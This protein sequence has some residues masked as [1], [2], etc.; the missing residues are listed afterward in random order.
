MAERK[1]LFADYVRLRFGKKPSEEAKTHMTDKEDSLVGKIEDSQGD[2]LG[3]SYN[4][5]AQLRQLATDRYGQYNA[6]DEISNDAT[7]ATA[8]ELYADDATQSDEQGR[9][10][11]VES[12]IPEI[13]KAGNRLL[14]IMEIPERAWGHIYMACKYG[15]FY[16]K[17]YRDFENED[18]ALK[19]NTSSKPVHIMNDKKQENVTNSYQEYVED[20]KD[21]AVIFELRTRGKTAGYVELPVDSNT[22][23]SNLLSGITSFAMAAND[24]KIYPPDRFVHVLL[25]DNPS[26][27]QEEMTIEYDSDTSVT[28][29][30]ARGKSALADVYGIQKQLTLLE[31]TLALTRLVRSPLIRLLEIEVGDMP[32]N[33][34][35]PYLRRF[36][37]LIENHISLDKDKGDYLSYAAPG[38]IDNLILVPTKNGKGASTV[39]TLGGDV[40]IK[41]IADINYYS[42]K[43]SGALK[44]P[45]QF[46]G[47]DMDGS[48]LS[49]GGSLTRL[50][51]QY[52]RT[53]KRMQR[54]YIRAITQLLNL[55]FLDKG[56]DY[57]GKFEVRMTSPSTQE[58]LER[59]E[60]IGNNVDLISGIMD[61]TNSLEGDTQKKILT[62]LV[63]N[64][65]K[66]PEIAEIIEGDSTPPEEIDI[67]GS[68]TGGGSSVD[69]DISSPGSGSSNIE[70]ATSVFSGELEPSGGTEEQGF[71]DEEYQEFQDT[72]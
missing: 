13:V 49:N 57:I 58:D 12:E 72:M 21:P 15:D 4:K 8:L 53:I 70:D 40:N 23:P 26:R 71:S 27:V 1:R 2:F 59:N 47:D 37:Q 45:R 61:L 30:V 39:N 55:F 10:I 19:M 34:V 29:Q 36:K 33:E 22:S 50:S 20:V 63:S 16:L 32:K 18:S 24:I 42:N 31:D 69:I 56:L 41:D 44:I 6:Y 11:W 52:A 64:V 68:G 7:I 51:I 48:G 43:R 3:Y 46:L 62:H 9:V 60:L 28:Y 67:E 5:L 38:P 14:D 17:L 66:M 65:L 54:A 25:S 35:N